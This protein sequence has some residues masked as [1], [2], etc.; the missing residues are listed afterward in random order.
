ML[1]RMLRGRGMAHSHTMQAYKNLFRL[2]GPPAIAHMVQ[3]LLRALAGP[4]DDPTDIAGL[5]EMIS[6]L[7]T[8][9]LKYVQSWTAHTLCARPR[10]CFQC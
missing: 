1:L 9:V 6:A 7:P 5:S 8:V 10:S 2:C 3:S 4:V